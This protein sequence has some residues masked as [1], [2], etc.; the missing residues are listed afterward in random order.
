MNHGPAMWHV[1][2]PPWTKSM[3]KEHGTEHDRCTAAISQQRELAVAQCAFRARACLEE[4]RGAG[5][6]TCGLPRAEEQAWDWLFS[7]AS[8]RLAMVV[9]HRSSR[10]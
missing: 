3:L 8:S 10:A 5:K 6:L 7:K 1:S 2:G 9:R 4:R